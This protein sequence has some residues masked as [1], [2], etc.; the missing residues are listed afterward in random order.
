MSALLSPWKLVATAVEVQLSKPLKQMGEH[1]TL[2]TPSRRAEADRLVAKFM[3]CHVST[4]GV[5]FVEV[6]HGVGP[7]VAC[8]GISSVSL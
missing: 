1:L 3:R 6:A 8:Q 2:G 5:D 7:T 4:K